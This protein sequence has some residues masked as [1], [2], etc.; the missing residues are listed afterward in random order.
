MSDDYELIPLD[1]V[2]K[3]K[4]EISA[5]KKDKKSSPASLAGTLDRL[6][7][8]LEKLF[9]IF[10]VAATDMEQDKLHEKTFEEKIQ[11]MMDKMRSVEQQNRDLAEGILA[12]ADIVKGI[13]RKLAVRDV[14]ARTIP[15]PR[16]AQPPRSMPS[17][18]LDTGMQSSMPP[19]GSSY[20]PA[21]SPSAPPFA[22]QMAPASAMPPP[23]PMPEEKEGIFSRFK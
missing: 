15:T 7:N 14:R 13:E 11:P 22:P 17:S 8:A 6:A 18:P 12:M 3:L 23:P 1:E 9:K 10:E 2:E 20:P 16:A 21:S 4:A 5:L 19:M